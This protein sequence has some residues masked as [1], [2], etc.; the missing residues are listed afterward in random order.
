LE[1][2]ICADAR[3][4]EEDIELSKVYKQ[5]KASMGTQAD[6]LIESERRWLRYVGGNC[7]LGVCE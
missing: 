6:D 7:P 1:I 3:F 2:V 5:A 4:G